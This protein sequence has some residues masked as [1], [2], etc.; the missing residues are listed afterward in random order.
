MEGNT[1]KKN[2]QKPDMKVVQLQQRTH[3]LAGSNTKGVKS[4]K[5]S[6][7]FSKND[8]GFGDYDVDM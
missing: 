4:I 7:N 2:Y 5:G 6:D 3:I 1:M 8:D